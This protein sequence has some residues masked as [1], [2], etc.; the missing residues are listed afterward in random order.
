MNPT[1]RDQGVPKISVVMAV[2]NK[3][4]YLRESVESVLRQDLGEFELICVDVAST[5]NSLEILKEYA[6]KDP[7]ITIFS[8]PYSKI[9]AVTKNIGI[10]STK[11]EYV[12]NLDADDYLRADTLKEM[13]T[14]AKETNAD[15]VIPDLQTVSL[16]GRY[17]QP[18]ISGVNGNRRILLT[19]RQAVTQS[20]D[21]T[22][23]GFALWKGDLIRRIRLEEFGAYSDE[24]SARVLFF[25]CKQVAFSGGLYFHRINDKS[26]TGKISLQ[27]YDRPDAIYHV[28]TFIEKQLFDEKNV[29]SLHFSVFK[30]C[31]FLL[32]HTKH[33]TASE[34]AEAQRRIKTVYNQIDMRRVRK[35]VCTL[36][37]GRAALW[38]PDGKVGKYLFAFLTF[39][40]WG[41]LN[42]LPLKLLFIS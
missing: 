39:L 11:G 5:D 10:D 22:I 34:I 24:Y 32:S 12:F 18:F 13:Y 4:P 31:C 36:T 8:T 21:W 2:Y 26:L 35:S 41:L 42:K 25:N 30:D 15:A 16:N 28:A 23:H 6:A 1:T 27:M 37:P 17:I 33:L 40:D 38:R 7:R 19:N 29:N 20:L 3:A 9:P 14:K